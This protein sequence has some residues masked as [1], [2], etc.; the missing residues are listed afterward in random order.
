MRKILVLCCMCLVWMIPLPGLAAGTVN[1]NAVNSDVRE[2][3]NAIA[4]VGEV[5]MILDDSVTGKMSLQLREVPFDTALQLVCKTKGLS[6]ELMGNVLVVGSTEKITKNFSDFVVIK[7]ENVKV[8]DIVDAVAMTLG[9]KAGGVT[10]EKKSDKKIAKTDE[11]GKSQDEKESIGMEKLTINYER[12]R[13]DL[14]TNSLIVKGSPEELLKVRK[15]VEELD[16]RPQQ[17]SIEVEVVS[18]DKTASKALGIEWE[19]QNAPQYPEYTTDTTTGK[20]TVKRS[21][22]KSSGSVGGIIQFGRTPEGYAYEFYYQSKINALITDGKA[23]VLA[24]PKVMAI[25]GKEAII[26]I[27]QSIPITSTVVTDTSTTTSVEYKNAGIVLNYVPR[28][29]KDGNLTAVIHTEVSSPSYDAETKLYKFNI[30]SA[31]T[32][33][34]VKD[35]ETMVIGGLIGKEE[36]NAYSKVPMLGDLP[37]IGA[38]FKSTS[39]SKTE[40]EVVIFLTAR[41]VK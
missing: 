24:K 36:S 2:V 22:F 37:L 15:L 11:K 21:A 19:W 28:V 14:P 18:L 29:G 12:V 20:T 33:V 27:G 41:I 13:M 1:I 40:S 34:L 26:N 23:K 38:L 4:A 6:Y 10:S 7:L 35:G 8:E 3:L 25:N 16:V 5:N 9:E 32:E 30:R 31:D 39:T 17:V